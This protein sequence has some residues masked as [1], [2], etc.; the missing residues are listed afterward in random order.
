MGTGRLGN[1]VYI[2]DF[3]L[4]KE[5]RD[6]ETRVHKPYYDNRTFGGTSRYA[7]INNHIGVG[8]YKSI[9]T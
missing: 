5:Y 4:T 3:D 7:S 9:Y 6:P 1:L 8:T 2:I